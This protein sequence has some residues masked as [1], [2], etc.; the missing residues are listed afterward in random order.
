VD[1]QLTTALRGLQA[2][3]IVAVAKGGADGDGYV[4]VND[5][6]IGVAAG[7][8][9][10]GVVAS[11]TTATVV[12]DEDPTADYRIVCLSYGG[13]GTAESLHV[14][15]TEEY[16]GTQSGDV[17]VDADTYTVGAVDSGG[18]IGTFGD[19]QIAWLAIYNRALSAS[20]RNFLTAAL[21]NKFAL[22]P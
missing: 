18:T 14:D 20:E 17:T 21:R 3:T 5:S 11:H 16:A 7:P 2:A 10:A 9:I 13:N 1:D 15:G 6:M 8:V 22:A 12:S 4:G 19:C